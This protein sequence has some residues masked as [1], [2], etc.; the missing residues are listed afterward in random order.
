MRI[1]F[2]PVERSDPQH[3][4]EH[5]GLLDGVFMGAERAFKMF[6]AG[7]GRRFDVV[8]AAGTADQAHGD[9]KDENIQQGDEGGAMH[10]ISRDV[11]TGMIE[12]NAGLANYKAL[13]AA[14][15]LAQAH[16]KL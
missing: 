5:H 7:A 2:E 3:R 16:W 13:A 11:C 6:V 12:G 4:Q 14:C 9:E 15:A 1:H 8:F 10:G